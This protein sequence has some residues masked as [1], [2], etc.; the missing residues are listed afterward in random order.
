MTE[1]TP[2]PR[3]ADRQFSRRSFIWSRIDA[4][5]APVAMFNRV[6]RHSE[7]FYSFTRVYDLAGFGGRSDALNILILVYL[8]CFETVMSRG[9]DALF[10]CDVQFTR[11]V[12]Y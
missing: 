9:C 11:F 7:S 4:L 6:S 8:C 2:A 12:E 1:E 10:A 5:C 3:L